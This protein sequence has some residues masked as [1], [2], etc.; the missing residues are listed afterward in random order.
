[1]EVGVIRPHIDGMLLNPG[2]SHATQDSRQ[3]PTGS[4]HQ[5]QCLY[6]DGFREKK[7]D[8]TLVLM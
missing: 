5:Q 3:F 8:R 7:L 1:M 4:F 6:N 2:Q